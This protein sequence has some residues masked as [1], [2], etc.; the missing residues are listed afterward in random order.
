MSFFAHTPGTAV[1][2]RFLR[3]YAEFGCTS[4]LATSRA[5]KVALTQTV[6]L[7]QQ[8]LL[9]VKN[10]A[11]MMNAIEDIA[12]IC[13]AIR[14][15]EEGAGLIYGF[16]TYNTFKKGWEYQK[17]CVNGLDRSLWPASLK[18]DSQ[19]VEDQRPVPDGIGPLFGDIQR[20]QI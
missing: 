20:S 2:I 15:R 19:L 5:L 18:A 11:E 13:I 7:D 1:A 4:H 10:F 8:K 14:H 17:S 9:A 12:G 6:D 16:L 3:D